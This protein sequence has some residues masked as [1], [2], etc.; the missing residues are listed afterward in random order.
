MIRTVECECR[1][2]A[3]RVVC[4]VGP[5]I[6]LL[7]LL[8]PYIHLCSQYTTA[9]VIQLNNKK[10]QQMDYNCVIPHHRVC[11]QHATQPAFIRRE[12]E[13]L[14]K[15][16]TDV[17]ITRRVPLSDGVCLSSIICHRRTTGRSTAWR[18]HQMCGPTEPRPSRTVHAR[19]RAPIDGSGYRP[20][21]PSWTTPPPDTATATATAVIRT[22]GPACHTAWP[23]QASAHHGACVRPSALHVSPPFYINFYWAHSMGP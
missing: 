19:P 4:F 11:W 9:M 1:L 15:W 6:I 16:V 21:Q 20:R 14:V 18:I 17:D 8:G 22:T 2:Y 3:H 23:L 5:P 13:N 10:Q 7:S 12:S